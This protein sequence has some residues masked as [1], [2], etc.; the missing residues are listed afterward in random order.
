MRWTIYIYIPRHES[1]WTIHRGQHH[2]RKNAPPSSKKFCFFP[3]DSRD[4]PPAPIRPLWRDELSELTGYT[5]E[6]IVEC[7][8]E[9]WNLYE[10]MFPS[11]RVSVQKWSIYLVYIILFR[12]FSLFVPFHLFCCLLFFPFFSPIFFPLF[13]FCSFLPVRIHYFR[14][15]FLLRVCVHFLVFFFVSSLKTP[16][17][18][19]FVVLLVKG[20]YRPSHSFWAKWLESTWFFN[21]NARTRTTWE[22]Y[23]NG[24]ILEVGKYFWNGKVLGKGKFLESDFFWN[25]KIQLG[26]GKFSEWENSSLEWKISWNEDV[27]RSNSS[28]IRA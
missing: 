19:G 16:F 14:F 24:N 7:G 13:F 8:E 18:C 17:L 6:D 27:L 9:L 22:N 15:F 10:E 21:P 12:F 2:P 1:V 26:M 3:L 28:K 4:R 5:V 23:G 25:G 20:L 11:H